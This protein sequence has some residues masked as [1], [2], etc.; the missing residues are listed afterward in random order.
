MGF[1][2]VLALGCVAAGISQV[3][4][5]RAAPGHQ[6]GVATKVKPR[7]P[8]KYDPATYTTRVDNAWFPLKPGVTYIYRGVEEDGHLRDV[9]TVTHRTITIEGVTCRVIRDKVY[10]EG[11]LR[12]TTRDY[13]TQDEDGNVWYFGEDT[14]ELSKSGKVTSREGTWRTGRHGAEAGIFMEANPQVGN[15]YRQEFL[16]G[17]AEDHYQVLSLSRE[18]KVPYGHFGVVKLR[19]NVELTKEWTPLEPHIRD[20]KYYVRGIGEVKET[21]V[22]GPLETLELVK[23][24]QR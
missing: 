8:P 16:R 10:V 22:K 3:S 11:R 23:I 20:H 13:Y 12:E 24:V 7:Q 14:A 18:I 9:F 15:Q 6:A 17:H 2:V 5:L 1:S 19:R 21:T 4:A